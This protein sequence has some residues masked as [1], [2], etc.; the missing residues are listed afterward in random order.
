[1]GVKGQPIKIGLGHSD[2]PEEGIGVVTLSNQALCASAGK[3]RKW[4]QYHHIMDPKTLASTTSLKAVWV[5]AESALFADGLATAL[6]FVAPDKLL[7]HYTFSY[8]LVHNDNSLSYSPDFPA[9]FFE[10]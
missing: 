9:E 5:A 6:F 1:M 4:A 3:R 7:R 8:A 2:N 10:A